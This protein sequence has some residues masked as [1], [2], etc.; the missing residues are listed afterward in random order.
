MAQRLSSKRYTKNL[1]RFSTH[2]R[3][4][5]KKLGCKPNEQLHFILVHDPK[6]KNKKFSSSSIHPAM[7]LHK[8]L[9]LL[10]KRTPQFTL[11]S[12]RNK[13]IHLLTQNKKGYA[14]FMEINY[15]ETRTSDFK[16]IRAQFIDVDLNKISMHLDTK[17]QVKQ[18]I[19]SIQ[20]DPAEQL[21]SITV[22]KTKQGKYYLLA[23][24]KKQRVTKLKNA[25]LKKFK[26]QIK[27]T[28]IIE[29]KNGYHIYWALQGGSVSK[30]VPI[31]KA[32]AKKFS[33]DPMI[34]N[35]SRVMRIPGFYHMK[36]PGS[37]FMV[38]VKQLG[39]KKP[40]SQ[41]EIIHSLALEPIQ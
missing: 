11:F 24:R 39:R 31:Q 7:T 19:E 22:K 38:R 15:R 23:L 35:L 25:F 21:Q 36:N 34:T 40:F 12:K 16:K 37:P 8:P 18:M 14:V 2:A 3:Q 28:M 20:S 4:F 9:N 10:E 17:E 26:T 32:L 33:S 1:R 30:F 5:I 6:N 27:D 41:E 29:T 13:L